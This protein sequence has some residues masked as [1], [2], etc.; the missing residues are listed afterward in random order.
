MKKQMKTKN[1]QNQTKI[2]N[3]DRKGSLQVQLC[4]LIY[5]IFISSPS[6]DPTEVVV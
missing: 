1:K 3:N 6:Q 2:S 5:N 4:A